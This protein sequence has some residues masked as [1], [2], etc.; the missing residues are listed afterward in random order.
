VS[1]LEYTPRP[2][3]DIV[4]DLLTTLTGGT[5]REAAIA[6]ADSPLVLD[7]LSSRPIRRVSH[8]NGVVDVGG[9][10]VQV[11]FTDADFYLADTNNDG[12]PDAIEFREN[13]RKPIPGSQL[14]VNYYPVQLARPVPLTDLNIGSVVRTLLETVAREVAQDEQ[15][16]DIIYRSAFLATAEGAALEKVVALIGVNRLPARHPLASIRFGRNAATGG[17]ITIPAGTVVT[18]GAT[19]PARYSTVTDLTL[20]AGEQSRSVL[21]AGVSVDTQVVDA[22]ALDRPETSIGGVSLVT[23]PD[24]AFRDSA[25]ETDDALRRRARGA[26]HGT[27]RGTLD[28]LR[29]GILS[30]PGVKAVE[31]TEWPDGQPGVVRAD[32]AYETPDPAVESAVRKRIDEVRPAGIRVDTGAATRRKV[33]ASVTLVLS[34]TGVSGAELTRLTSGVEDRVAK[35]LADLAPGAPIR[36]A[37]L[38]A[39]TLEDPLIAD[40]EIAL[41]DTAAPPGTPIV[42]QPGEVLDVVRP[43]TFPPPQPERAATGAVATAA[44]VDLVLPVAL[45]AGVALADVITAVQLAVDPQLAAVGPTNPLTLSGLASALQASPLFGLVREQASILVESGGQFVQLL[46]D[47][48]SYTPAP[49]ERL[50]RRTLDVHEAAG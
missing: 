33:S 29:F 50:R 9:T 46:D 11:Q 38:T 3:P 32:V 49:G 1:D 19:P 31:L 6:P 4:R 27:V 40:A 26:L 36:M 2:Y 10:P 30:V 8:L 45:Q 7:R 44:D 5:V 22:G 47:Q 12:L 23:N 42:L 21:A 20:E 39:A 28:A 16:L 13:G 15:Y 35:K 37:A 14:T 41:A 43:F 34:G 18:D 25:A 48:G 24:P 17:R